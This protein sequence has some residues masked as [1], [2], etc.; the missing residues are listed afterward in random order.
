MTRAVRVACARARSWRNRR[1]NYYALLFSS[2]RPGLGKAARGSNG[3]PPVGGRAEK[4]ERQRSLSVLPAVTVAFGRGIPTGRCS[5]LVTDDSRK[6][7]YHLV[8]IRAC[9]CSWA[10]IPTTRS[11]SPMRRMKM[12]Q[13]ARTQRMRQMSGQQRLPAT[14]VI[15]ASA[16]SELG[17]YLFLLF[18]VGVKPSISS[19]SIS[20]HKARNSLSLVFN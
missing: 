8:F 10:W 1:Q 12:N 19:S 5:E 18:C 7:M 2:Q 3:G 6:H 20:S 16:Q 11:F 14:V 17:T 4:T 13:M 15:N 9:R